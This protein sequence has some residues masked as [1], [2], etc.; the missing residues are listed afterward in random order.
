MTWLDVRTVRN[1][2]ARNPV[3]TAFAISIVIHGALFGGWRLGKRLG[4]WEHQA[5]WLL[6]LTKKKKPVPLLLASDPSK[7]L[8]PTPKREIPLSFVEVEPTV[9]V[10]EPPK[11]TKFY[12]ALNSVVAN[13]EP[14]VEKPVP[15]VD[16]AQTKL[17]RLEDVPKPGP[18]PLQPS[19]PPEKP[20]P[21]KP[22]PQPEPK[23]KAPDKPGDMAKAKPDGVRVQSDVRTEAAKPETPVV[24]RQKPRTLAE[25]RQAK[26]MLAG[27]KM[28]QDGGSSRRG[29]ISF[30]V[31]ATPF[32]A[33]DAAFIA[34]VQ[35][36]WYDLIDSSQFTPRAGRVVLE[37]RLYSDGRITD[38][39]MNGNEV[40]QML[41]LLCERAVLDPAP[42][43]K[44][45][46]D[47]LR[48]I[49]KNYREIRF[50]FYYE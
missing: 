31:K 27:E 38:L 8:L 41:G 42:Y 24:P 32:G 5:T 6:K 36:R 2:V 16:G 13:P 44:W 28:K 14:M 12:G 50:T 47:M 26:S 15:K 30:D 25:A 49:E 43:P 9:A 20:A 45:P 35:Q 22:P 29:K 34:A 3:A 18:Q 21:D 33:Y 17:V 7:Q 46:S 1:W 10:T 39:K 4:W 40:G 23:P 48:M 11:D 37:F 19:L